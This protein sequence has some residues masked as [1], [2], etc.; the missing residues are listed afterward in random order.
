MKCGITGWVSIDVAKVHTR[1]AVGHML[2]VSDGVGHSRGFGDLHDI[3]DRAHPCIPLLPHV[4][5]H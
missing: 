5:V 3:Q 2:L 1:G 4:L